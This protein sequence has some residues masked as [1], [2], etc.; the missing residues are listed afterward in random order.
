MSEAQKTIFFDF[1]GVMV[2]SFA[3]AFQTMKTFFPDPAFTES[4]FRDL[5]EGNFYTSVQ[6]AKVD[7][8]SFNQESFFEIYLPKLFTLPPVSGIDSVI[9]ELSS[10]YR[11]SI[12]TSALT[13][14]VREWL[15]KNNLHVFFD[16]VLGADIEKSKTK[17]M[18]MLFE[19]YHIQQSD[20]LFITDTIGDILEA[21]Q[22]HVHSIAVT[23]GFHARENLLHGKPVSI[24][25]QP[26][27]LPQAVSDFFKTV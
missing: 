14:P 19:K 5:F 24:V 3:L 20:C 25:D 23:Y 26:Q 12:I 7:M 6:K 21:N 16:D 10:V 2:D 15:E 18:E 1:D 8:R 27:E 9:K 11:L 17:K 4:F 13:Q 22:V